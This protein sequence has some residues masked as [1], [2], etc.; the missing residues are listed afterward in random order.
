MG[1]FTLVELLV[2]IAVIAILA[3]LLLPA[4]A[5]AKAAAQRSY[6][7]NNERQLAMTA[8][9]YCVDN[10]DWLPNN[11]IGNYYSPTNKQWVSG[12]FADYGSLTNS[13]YLL[14]SRYSQFA[15]YLKNIKIYVCPADPSDIQVT[16]GPS[17]ERQAFENL[18]VKLSGRL[19][20]YAMNA[21]VGWPELGAGW[22]NRL[23]T[24]Y[25]VFHKQ[26]D[27]HGPLGNFLFLD[28]NPKSICWPYFGVY[29]DTDNIFNFPG[30]AHAKGSVVSFSDGHTEYHRWEDDRTIQAK[31]ANYHA[32]ADSSPNNKDLAWLRD[33][34]TVPK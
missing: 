8:M 6:C 22:D 4:L 3:A 21:Y 26:T 34:T 28:V 31:S 7:M 9:L 18:S 30:I 23:S 29:M 5:K 15:N 17:G 1:G 10:N 27:M 2:V 25:K 16:N 19:R 20:S 33:R 24:K 13:S 11:G 32:H 12:Y 14:D